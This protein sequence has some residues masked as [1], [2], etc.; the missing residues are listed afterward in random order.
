MNQIA[1]GF[2]NDDG[3]RCNEP[4]MGFV[5]I[6]QARIPCCDVHNVTVPVVETPHAM[7]DEG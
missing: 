7:Q 5:T 2:L 1:C 6:V 4:A 3:S